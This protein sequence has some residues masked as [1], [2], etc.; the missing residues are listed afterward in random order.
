MPL[1]AEPRTT[2]LFPMVRF[3]LVL[4]PE[5]TPIPR[6]LLPAVIA[7]PENVAVR[8]DRSLVCADTPLKPLP[9][10]MTLFRSEAVVVEALAPPSA[11]SAW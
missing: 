2:V 3:M 5:D 8:L 1:A 6:L 11:N 4:S 10:D 9:P 7:F